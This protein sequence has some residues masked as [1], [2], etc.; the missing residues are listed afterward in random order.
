M[1]TLNSSWL[2]W[3]DHFES[4]GGDC[5]GPDFCR[6]FG[7][8]TIGEGI[9]RCY[10][11]LGFRYDWVVWV[12]KHSPGKT[13]S[14]TV[15]YELLRLIT[16]PSDDCA[17]ARAKHIYKVQTL[18]KDEKELVLKTIFRD[19]KNRYSDFTEVEVREG[20]RLNG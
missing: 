18:L 8:I 6:K 5:E 15:R 10:K 7:D 14:T 13:T 17:I 3:M 11:A 1:W 4:I 16:S 9:A 12:F 20:R 2:A 19:D